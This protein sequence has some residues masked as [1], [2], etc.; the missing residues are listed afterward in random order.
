MIQQKRWTAVFRC[1]LLMVC[2]VFFG[3]G[4]GTQAKA[5]TV[6]IRVDGVDVGTQSSGEAGRMT[7][8]P[9]C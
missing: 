3:V 6:G 9:M 5:D 1:L 4:G 7:R 2:M 8:H